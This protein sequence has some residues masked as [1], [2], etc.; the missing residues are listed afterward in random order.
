MPIGMGKPLHRRVVPETYAQ[1]LY[2][3][4][5]A[6]GHT[7]ESVLGEPWPEHD[8]T[9][10]GGVDVDRWERMLACA[11]QHLGDPLLGLHVGQTITA[12]HLGILGPVL[13]ACDNLGAALQ[14]LERYQRLIFDVVPMSQRAGP[15]W[16]DVVWDISRYRPGRLVTET[17]F[18]VFTQFCRSIVRGVANLS[19]VEFAH[20][21]PTDVRPYEDFFGCP[22]KFERPEPVIRVGL[23]FLASPLKSPD[24]GLILV[25]EQHADRLLSQL[26]QEAEVIEQVRKAIAH[27]LLEGEPDIEKVSVKLCCSSRTLQRRLRTAGTGFRDELNFVRYQLATSYLRDPRLQI[28]DVALLLGYSEH[29]A[30]TRAFREWVGKTPQQVREESPQRRSKS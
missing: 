29:S 10:L 15:G 18:A 4:L 14:R 12:R 8:P 2:E 1:L 22:V 16:V 20:L 9:G 28:V 6:H 19:A 5:E 26:P 24:P 7:P 25:L 17:G 13:L 27:L 11:E 3:Y 23:D 30:F 21:E